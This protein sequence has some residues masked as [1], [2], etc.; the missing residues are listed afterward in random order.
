V[1]G[2]LD[3]R[4]VRLSHPAGR[5]RFTVVTFS[6]WSV[7]KLWDTGHVFVMLDARGGSEA[8]HYVHVRSDGSRLVANLWRVRTG[9]DL[10]IGRVRVGR[11]SPD[12]VSVWVGLSDLDI[13]PKRARYRWWVY[14]TFVGGRCRATC[15][16][17]VPQSGGIEQALPGPS[18]SPSPSPS[19][20]G[21]TGP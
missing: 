14:T 7:R 10:R 6:T 1:R 19:P 12:A 13:G 17:R 8:D 21:V 5:H 2:V 3:V 18:P 11:P 9:R 20:T 4:E 15:I 16:D